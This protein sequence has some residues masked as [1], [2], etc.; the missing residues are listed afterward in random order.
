MFAQQ[1]SRSRRERCVRVGGRWGSWRQRPKE[2]HRLS[3]VAGLSHV[4]FV[5][6]AL[7]DARLGAVHRHGMGLHDALEALLQLRERWELQLF[8]HVIEERFAGGGDLPGGNAD[9]L[10]DAADRVSDDRFAASGAEHQPD[11]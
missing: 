6:V 2:A 4:G 7:V 8:G 11:R 9:R 1:P 3:V 10:V 5:I